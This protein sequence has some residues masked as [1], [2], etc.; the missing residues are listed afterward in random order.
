MPSPLP[1]AILITI[2]TLVA[3]YT[4]LLRPGVVRSQRVRQWE[5]IS[6]QVREG[7]IAPSKAL[8]ERL[9]A[10]G[11]NLSGGEFL[12]LMTG[13]GMGVFVVALGMGVPWLVAAAL[14]CWAAT[15][16]RSRLAARERARWLALDRELPGA[17]SLLVGNLRVQPDLAEALRLT[18][19]TLQ[20]GGQ[21]HLAGEFLRTAAEMRALGAEAA[22]R[23]L[24]GRSPSPSLGLVAGALRLYVQVGG[25]FIP[26]LEKK[27]GTIRDLIATREEAR[28]S[29][30][31]ALLAGKAIP[32]LLVMV[33]MGLLRDPTFGAFYR[34]LLGQFVLLLCGAA[35]V[36]GY[37][38][39][40]SMV[41]EVA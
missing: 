26:V 3:L 17:L 19:A 11:W 40:K 22:L 5:Q 6:G 39:M 20:A 24:E 29:A 13:L 23:S 7:D 1:A 31:D 34:S 41:E 35:M 33:T 4:L 8:E 36:L 10:A 14:G 16:P 28:T 25:D 9:Q 2:T 27:G 30:A 15:F 18:A 32:V 12:V 21:P 38:A 37:G